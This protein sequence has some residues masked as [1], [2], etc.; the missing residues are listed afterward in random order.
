[1]THARVRDLHVHSAVFI[2]ATDSIERAGQK[3]R[4]NNTSALFVRNGD[5]V[6]IITGMNLVKAVVLKRIPIEA[7][8]QSEAPHYEVVA[9]SPDDFVSMALLKMAKHNKRRVSIIDQ[10]TYVGILDDI[11]LLS[12]LAG[13]SQLVAGR[14]DGANALSELAISAAGIEGQVR[15]LRRQGVNIE[16]VSEIVSDLNR[17][18]FRKLFEMTA[19]GDIRDKACLIVMGSEG[20]GEQTIRTDQDNGLILSEPIEA[21]ELQAFRALFSQSQSFGFSPCPGNVLLSNPAWSKT[22]HD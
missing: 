8:V 16:V 17:H 10:G 9:V 4:E 18:H 19:T 5:E 14:I 2:E 1:M 12:F 11:D 13:N 22:L 15:M 7:A 3:M 20:R 6:G 21:E